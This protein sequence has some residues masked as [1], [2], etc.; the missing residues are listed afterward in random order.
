MRT[1]DLIDKLVEAAMPVRRLR[2][3]AVRAALWLLLAVAILGLLA[4][5]HG[6][7]ADL[8]MRLQQPMFVAGL[9]GALATAILG[10]VAAFV[11]LTGR[12]SVQALTVSPSWR[13]GRIR[14]DERLAG[15]TSPSSST[16]DRTTSR[17]STTGL[18]R[19]PVR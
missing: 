15:G 1:P 8:A 16:S 6:V 14:V 9:A 2:P 4:V 3:P 17:S 10:A 12:S 13:I 7:R 5:G 18:A 11:A 19:C